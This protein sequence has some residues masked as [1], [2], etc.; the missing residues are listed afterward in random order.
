MGI[1]FVNGILEP[2]PFIGVFTPI[3]WEKVKTE[4]GFKERKESIRKGY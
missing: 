1:K 4:F 3:P 2:P